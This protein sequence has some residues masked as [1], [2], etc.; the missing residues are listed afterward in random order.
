MRR[1]GIVDVLTL[2]RAD[3]ERL[4]DRDTLLDALAEAFAALSDGRVDAPPRNQV[5]APAGFLLAM[6]AHRPGGPIGVKLV[7]VFEGNAARG[8]PTHLALVA[9]FDERTGAPIALLDGTSITAARTAGAAALSARLAARPDSRVLAIVGAGVQARAHLAAL[10]RV[11]PID[12]IR[13]ASL[14]PDEAAALASEAPRARAIGS[15]E[16]AV[17]GAD[18]VCLCTSAPAAIVDAAWIAHGTHVTSVGYHPPAGELP[19][20]LAAAGHLFVETRR[21]FEPPPMGCGELVGLDPATGTE[22]G[23]VVLG[24]RPGRRGSNEITVYKAM[25]HAVEDLAAATLVYE[26]ALAQGVGST[27]EL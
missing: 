24:R 5:S 14:Y 9:L 22:L 7:S 19:P 6:P 23:E 20:G 16:E 18:V 12:E 2:G 26:R 21:A 11:L 27:I 17:R 8:L 10:P 13:V 3:V 15:I 25:G 1:E 4:L